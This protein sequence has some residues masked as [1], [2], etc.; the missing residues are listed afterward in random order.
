MRTNREH[1]LTISPEKDEMRSIVS[2]FV[3]RQGNTI[4]SRGMVERGRMGVT[5]GVFRVKG[6][7]WSVFEFDSFLLVHFSLL[8]L[9]IA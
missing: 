4:S 1:R 6:A 7:A 8:I 2:G 9:F 3:F 5:I